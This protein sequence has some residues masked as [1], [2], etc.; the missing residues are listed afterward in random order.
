M[1]K[2]E[3]IEVLQIIIRYTEYGKAMLMGQFPPDMIKEYKEQR[4]S[5]IRALKAAVEIV[6]RAGEPSPPEEPPFLTKRLAIPARESMKVIYDKRLSGKTTKLIQECA[7]DGYSL[8]VE[9]NKGM[10]DAT[11]GLAKQLG[12]EIPYPISFEAFLRGEFQGKH[13]DHFYID[14]LQ[15]CLARLCKGVPIKTVTVTNYEF[16]EAEAVKK[17]TASIRSEELCNKCV[18]RHHC[19]F[20]LQ[21]CQICPYRIGTNCYC[22]TVNPGEPCE[23]FLER[24][25]GRKNETY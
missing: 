11:F 1:R 18:R 13:I 4:D 24:S 5:E 7:K 23:G 3:I 10:C 9:P 19:H 21:N 2:S 22:L 17:E 25:E 15:M 12:Y 16:E 6:K 20:I 8:I 14:E